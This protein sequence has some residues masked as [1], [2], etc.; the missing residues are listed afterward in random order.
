MSGPSTASRPLVSVVIATIG[1]PSLMNTIARLNEGTVVPAE[2]L[3]CIPEKG[4]VVADNLL[5]SNVEIVVCNRRGQVAQ[6]VVGFGRAK[7]DYVLQLDDDVE[8]GEHCLERLVHA[9]DSLGPKAAVAPTLIFG[10]TGLP[11]YRLNGDRAPSRIEHL[12]HGPEIS[13]P[14]RITRA[15]TNTPLD[16]SSSNEPADATEWVPGACVLHA[17]ENLVRE[18]YYPFPGKAYGEDVIHSIFLMRR[19]IKLFVVREALCAMEPAVETRSTVGSFLRDMRADWR[20]RRYL[21][22]MTGGSMSKLAAEI[23]LKYA[24]RVLPAIVRRVT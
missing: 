9:L 23:F 7:H 21:V 14:G 17:R 2:I 19:G 3:V 12:L 1:A 22:R 16:F 8:V 4:S 20:W 15:A 11:V 13:L 24:R 10:G 6:R 18:N 5:F